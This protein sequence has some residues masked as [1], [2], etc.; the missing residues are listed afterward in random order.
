MKPAHTNTA[1]LRGV[2]VHY[3]NQP[4]RFVKLPDLTN[5]LLPHVKLAYVY[6]L[7]AAS[8]LSPA[9]DALTH[10]MSAIRKAQFRAGRHC[11][12][13]A[14][15]RLGVRNYPI[16]FQPERLPAW[17]PFVTG[18]ISHTG[19]YAIAAVAPKDS[20]LS[21]GVDAEQ[22]LPI[23][24]ALWS[25]IFAP[26]EIARLRNFPES[27]RTLLAKLLFSA[28]ESVYKCQYQYFSQRI[29]FQAIGISLLPGHRRFNVHLP[30]TALSRIR[31][32]GLIAL[33]A[34]LVVTI[35][36]IVP[37]SALGKSHRPR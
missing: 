22:N 11:A 33:T 2:L 15:E 19:E 17:P 34:D 29:L 20:V 7:D 18:S 30:F 9:E 12:R 13:I 27:E 1:L 21:I 28:K 26:E 24:E 23:E 6:P 25:F 4:E 16:L 31:L 32:T 3:L 36:C 35:C 8:E 37:D 5:F 14:L 10:N